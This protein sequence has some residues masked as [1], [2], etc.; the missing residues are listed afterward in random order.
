M[1]TVQAWPE[2]PIINVTTVDSTYCDTLQAIA[3]DYCGQALPEISLN[4]QLD[5]ST[6]DGVI[7]PLNTTTGLNSQPATA[8]YCPEQGFVGTVEI[9]VNHVYH[10]VRRP[11]LG[12][13]FGD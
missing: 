9:D 5:T 6:Y 10:P 2:D 8:L 11:H 13:C 1:N 3:L 12:L 4:F 7:Y